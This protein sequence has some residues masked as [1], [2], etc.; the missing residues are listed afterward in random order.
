MKRSRSASFVMR[1]TRLAGVLG[2]DVIRR[3]WAEHL[4]G[5]DLDVG[6]LAAGSRRAA[7]GS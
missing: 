6:G 4:L 5:I 1:S 2:E 3:C 7:G